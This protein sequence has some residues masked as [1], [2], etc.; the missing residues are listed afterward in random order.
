M[1]Y[2]RR[3]RAATLAAT[4]PLLLMVAAQTHAPAAPVQG[5]TPPR[6]VTLTE[7]APTALVDTVGTHVGPVEALATRDQAGTTEDPSTYVRLGGPDVAY[8]GYRTYTLP[9]SVPPALVTT[10]TLAANFRGPTAA[11]KAWTW[12]VYDWTNDV[13]VRVGT[14]NH[15]GGD[16]GTKKWPCDDLDRAPWKYV[17]SNVIHT[18]GATLADFVNP[19]TREIRIRLAASATGAAKLDFEAVE[20]YSNSGVASTP[21]TPAVGTRWQWQ[22]QGKPGTYEATGGIDVEV[23]EPPF[24]GGPCVRP[25]VFDFDLYVDPSIA[26]RYGWALETAAVDAVHASGRHAIGYVTAG[27]AERWRPDYA[28]FVD[29]DR[30]CGGC[31]LG[32]PFS[33]RFPDEYWASFA[34]G[35]GRFSFM[36]QMLRAR[37]DRVAATGFDGI[38]YDI[39]DTYANDPHYTGIRVSAQTQLAYNRAL[40]AMAH[41][42][43]LSVALKNDSGQIPDLLPDFDYAIN[44]E[45]FQWD[46]CGAYRAFIEAGKPVFHA[47]YELGAAAFCPRTNRWGFSSIKKAENYSL[48]ALPWTPCG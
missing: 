47:E 2:A 42:D 39:V 28:Q 1:R 3:A 35:H 15:C 8:D 36:V 40:A 44:E 45:C 16:A 41:A 43:G 34:P 27:D 26:G 31:L 23:C 48:F 7:L 13:W 11:K 6:Q 19:S 37:T 10:I 22:L 12:S 33:R 25:D 29:F 20:V 32:N 24:G 4:V 30:A 14:Q 46:E 5:T 18:R 17:R 9:A 21:W 38:E